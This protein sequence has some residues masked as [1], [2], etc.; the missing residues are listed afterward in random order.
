MNCFSRIRQTGIVG[1]LFLFL[2]TGALGRAQ[3]GS[4]GAPTGVDAR[5]LKLFGSN[6]TFTARMDVLV[7]DRSGKDWAR[8][9]L[10]LTAAGDRLRLDLD[11]EQIKSRDLPGFLVAS[12]KEVGL[13]RVVNLVLPE[14]KSTYVIYP[15]MRSY[16]NLPL[17]QAEI[18]SHQEGYRIEKTVLGKET[19][20][21]HPCARNKVVVRSGE[22]AVLEATTWEATD[23]RDFPMKIETREKENVIQLTLSGIKFVKAD[24]AQFA[25]PA[26]FVEYKDPQAMMVGI[27]KRIT[28]GSLEIK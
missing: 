21:G 17:T 25:V 6:T 1:C 10:D 3:M 28:T 24:A 16:L 18:E 15:G 7:L 12:L 20:E 13:T 8:L 19:V 27:M 14:K 26:G 5:F 11:V 22:R 23:L 9:P 2:V 4:F